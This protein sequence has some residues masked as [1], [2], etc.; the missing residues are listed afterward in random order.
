MVHKSS[1]GR[2]FQSSI[3]NRYVLSLILCC[4][5]SV[6]LLILS[7]SDAQLIKSLRYTTISI[8]KPIFIIIRKPF[9]V[10]NDSLTLLTFLYVSFYRMSLSKITIEQCSVEILTGFMGL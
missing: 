2:G 10:F 3:L 7:I 5:F 6:I 4:S 9:Q 1:F 8:S